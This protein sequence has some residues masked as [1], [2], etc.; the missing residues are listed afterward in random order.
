LERQRAVERDRTRIAKDIH[1]DLGAGLTQITLLSELA[2]RE[3]ADKMGDQLE[4][5]SDSARKLTRTIDEIVWAVDPQHDTLN[6]LMDYISAYT[7]DFLRV[8]GIRCRM[9]LPVS[10]PAMHVPAELRYNLFLALKETLNNIVKHAGASEVSLGLQ[11]AARGFTLVV[12]DN[13]RGI[14]SNGSPP[15]GSRL[16]SGHGLSNLE[17]RLA[18][19]GGA[20]T[21][22]SSSGQGTRVEMQV[23]LDG[24]PSPVVAIGST[25]H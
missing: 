25:H 3:P 7:E 2:R 21:I 18:A 4:R 6:G 23:S 10:L 16:V 24:E 22:E 17:T 8:A 20:Y 5:I 11:L 13:G 12:H 15:N 14:S 19:V 9:D 1:D